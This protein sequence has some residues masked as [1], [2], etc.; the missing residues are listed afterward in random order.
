MCWGITRNRDMRRAGRGRS[1]TE[2]G[3]VH[4]E[5]PVGVGCGHRVGPESWGVLG[6]GEG[7][8]A[9]EVE[10][11]RGARLSCVGRA[12]PPAP[13]AAAPAPPSDTRLISSICSLFSP[14]RRFA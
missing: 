14:I 13:P 1:L 4:E 11:E 9:A 3:S 10:A 7:E 2:Y 5:A 8:V 12:A 6:V